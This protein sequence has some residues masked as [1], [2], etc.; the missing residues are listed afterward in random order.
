MK[1]RTFITAIPALAAYAVIPKGV[2]GE[3]VIKADID[4]LS[5]KISMRKKQ[6]AVFRAHGLT[7]ILLNIGK[8]IRGG[9]TQN[10]GFLSLIVL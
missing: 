2:L 6:Q 10:C 8:T 5:T 1:R 3:R 4:T 7:L 9:L